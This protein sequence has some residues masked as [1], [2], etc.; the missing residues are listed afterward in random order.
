M[1]TFSNP[2]IILIFGTKT[3]FNKTIGTNFYYYKRRNE[4]V[5]F[6]GLKLAMR[7]NDVVL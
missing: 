6:V 2:Y 7:G 3:R 4:T 5:G 1:E